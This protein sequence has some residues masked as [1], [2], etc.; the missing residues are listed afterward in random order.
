MLNRPS[1]LNEDAINRL[2]QIECNVM[3]DEILT[4]VETMKA[5]QHVSS[6]KAPGADAIPAKIYKAGGLLKAERKSKVYVTTTEASLS[7]Q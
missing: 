4:V 5:I 3:L 7:Y 2:P 1:S 6:G